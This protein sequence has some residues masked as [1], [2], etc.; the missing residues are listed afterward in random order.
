MRV[1]ESVLVGLV[2]E[3]LIARHSDSSVVVA[4]GEALSQHL[5]RGAEKESGRTVDHSIQATCDCFTPHAELVGRRRLA[6]ES[7][8]LT[9]DG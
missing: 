8:V 9:D 2:V 4:A 7:G 3:A 6:I 5:A 1:A